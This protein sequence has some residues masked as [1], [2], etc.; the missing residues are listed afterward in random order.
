M[1]K[2]A[3][4]AR[5]LEDYADILEA[6]DDQYRPRSYRRA[7]QNIRDYPEA[8]EDLV[9]E[10]PEAV[11]EIEG[12]GESIADKVIEFVETGEI[13]TIEEAKEE[14]PVEMRE[15]TRVEGVGPK[16]VG[17]LYEALGITTLDELETAAREQKI[18]EIKGFGPKTEENILEHIEFAKESRKRELLGEA[19]PIAD[20]LIE[21]LGAAEAVDQS[22]PAGSLRRW[23]ETVGDI[24]VL[25]AGADH[26]AVVDRFTGWEGVTDIIEAGTTKASIRADG[27]RVDL[28]VVDPEEWGSALQYFTGSKDHNVRLRTYAIKR[29]LKINEYGLF[30][31]SEVDDPDSGQRVGERIAGETEE[32]IYEALDLPWIP[33]ELR[34]DNG[35]IDAAAAGDLPTLLEVDEIRGDLHVHTDWSDGDNTI[36]EMIHG[37][38]EFGHD[39]LCISDHASGPGVVG[40]TGLEEADLREQL[41]T[42]ESLRGESSITVFSGVETNISA[43]GEISIEDDVLD[44]L[45]I[46]VASPHS[47]LEGDGTDRLIAAIEHPHV[48]IIGHPSGRLINRRPGLEYDIEAVASA[49]TD[50]GVALEVNANPHR[51]D[52]W[53]E[54]VRTAIEAGAVIS[55]NTDAHGPPEF[56]HLRFGV[57]TARRGWAEADDVINTWSPDDLQS[58]IE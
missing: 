30:D 39:Y 55:I 49:A 27:M 26:E 7:A 34:E 22:A 12:V 53:G 51:L 21:Y 56:H 18:R 36:E 2:N 31:V 41:Q 9:A 29:D 15:L 43:D 17:A 11:Q 13:E 47:G 37:A 4:V 42:I 45:D 6:Q 3:A 35:E 20:D 52:L 58:F 16:T 50:H 33:P 25:A 28:R 14:F 38:A 32:E 8:V 54:A 24:D 10:G 19:R 40:G 5:I 1:R 57:H 44:D 46:V 48:D 23:R